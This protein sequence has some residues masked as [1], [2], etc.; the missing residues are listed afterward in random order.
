MK[1]K[2][3]AWINWSNQEHKWILRLWID[4]EWAFSK[5]WSVFQ[6]GYSEIYDEPI[7]AIHD[8][9]LCE[10]AHLQDLGYNVKVTC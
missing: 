9:I 2:K 5:S 8:S 10:I 6:V 1:E 3:S 7:E 4:D